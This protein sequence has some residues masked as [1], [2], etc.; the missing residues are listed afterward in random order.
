[1]KNIMICFNIYYYYLYYNI[2]IY[3]SDKKELSLQ[4]SLFESINISI[5]SLN[6]LEVNLTIILLC[7]GINPINIFISL[8]SKSLFIK[9]L[10]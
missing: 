2:N 5:S 10:I 7:S 4:K 8:K 6:E 1:M 3:S 9:C